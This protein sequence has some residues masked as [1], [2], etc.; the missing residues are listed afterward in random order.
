MVIPPFSLVVG[1]PAKVKKTYPESIIEDV[2]HVAAR[3][4]QERVE[5]FRDGLRI[6]AT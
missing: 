2:I 4:Y 6:V 5:L 1:S 3:A